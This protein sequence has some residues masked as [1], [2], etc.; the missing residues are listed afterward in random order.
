MRRT[1]LLHALVAGLILAPPAQAADRV[2]GTV[3]GS[4][5]GASAWGGHVVF[6]VEDPATQRWALVQATAGGV[7]RLN[8]P[9]QAR[10]FDADVGPDAAGRPVAVYSRCADERRATGCHVYELALDDPSASERLVGAVDAAGYNDEAPTIWKGRIAFGRWKPS[11]GSRI[12]TVYIQRAPGSRRLRPLARGSVPSCRGIRHC[13]AFAQPVAMDLGSTGLAVLWSL[14]GGN[15]YPQSQ[16]LWRIPLDGA[17]GTLLDVGGVGECA[18]VTFASPGID[19]AGTSYLRATGYC[20]PTGSALVVGGPSWIRQRRHTFALPTVAYAAARDGAHWWSI[21]GVV[22]PSADANQH[23]C[24]QGDCQVVLSDRVAFSRAKVRR[25]PLPP[26]SCAGRVNGQCGAP[27]AP[28]TAAQL[29]RFLARWFEVLRTPRRPVDVLPADVRAALGLDA[30]GA[31]RARFLA[32]IGSYAMYIIPSGP[33]AVCL[34]ATARPVVRV[35][36][37]AVPFVAGR[38]GNVFPLLPLARHRRLLVGVLPDGARRV[39][40]RARDGHAIALHPYRNVVARVLGPGGRWTLV[41]TSR[42]GARH[43]QTVG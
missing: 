30:A 21:Q 15:A 12:A 40:L 23:P 28:T 24:G 37:G 16:E 43:R 39:A 34:A 26:L 31:A 33:D 3:G 18:Y 8:V 4:V 13:S 22:P 2:V 6:S 7:T 20:A 5:S 25:R 17:K 9:A 10:S 19:G 41:W 29:R 1:R 38:D 14:E 36:A 42:A 27:R 35:C 11:G 32:R